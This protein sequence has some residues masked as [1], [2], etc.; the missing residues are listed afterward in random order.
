MSTDRQ[1]FLDEA[2]DRIRM[3]DDINATGEAIVK[4]CRDTWTMREAVALPIAKGPWV[5]TVPTAFRVM[6]LDR[7][8]KLQPV[9]A[10][11]GKR[12]PIIIFHLENFGSA[13]ESNIPK[14]VHAGPNGFQIVEMDLSQVYAAFSDTGA[15]PNE[16]TLLDEILDALS[17]QLKGLPDKIEETFTDTQLIEMRGETFGAW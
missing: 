3:I 4:R 15:G 7:G 2:N 5:G 10:R 8:T 13:I 1:K 9:G 17:R 12:G 16:V 11:R 6:H 14:A